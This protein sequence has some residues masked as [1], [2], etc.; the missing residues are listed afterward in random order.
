MKKATLL[1]AT[2]LVGHELLRML[3]EDDR[4]EVVHVLAR[5]STGVAHERLREHVGDLS[6]MHEQL[7]AFRVDE[8]FCALGTTIKVAGSQEA[9]RAIDY[10]HVMRA[11][12]LG[13]EHGVTHFLLVSSLGAHASSRFFYNRVKGEVERDVGA[14]GYP[15]LTIAQP[16]LLLGSRR[17]KRFGE[18]VARRF[19][20]LTP[21][22]YKPIEAAAVARALVRSAN[23]TFSGVR[24]L[25]SQQMRAWHARK[26]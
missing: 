19:G 17:E 14:L 4:Y 1:G 24:V 25:S 12:K 26:T 16:S 10:G 6:S 20:W 21:A 11:A 5:R 23:E 15:Q 18:E 8:L 13:R 2:G 7:E 3:L 22:T 9:F